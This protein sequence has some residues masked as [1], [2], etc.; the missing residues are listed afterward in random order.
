[1]KVLFHSTL[2][3]QL[4]AHMGLEEEHVCGGS[5]LGYQWA[6]KSEQ[7]ATNRQERAEP[8]R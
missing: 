7:G 6:A 5:T 1:M 8:H 3:L 4:G 2:D